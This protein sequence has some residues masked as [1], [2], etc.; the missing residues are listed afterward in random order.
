MATLARLST[1][2]SR[3]GTIPATAAI[4][5]ITTSNTPERYCENPLS[6]TFAGLLVGGL[7]GGIIESLTPP[8]FRALVSGGILLSTGAN[9]FGR[10][11][12]WI[13]P[14]KMFDSGISI[15]INK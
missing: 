6:S 10:S 2:L 14:P 9:I 13:P 11:M 15:S 12:G 7:G 3:D 4:S 1:F 8:Q 5:F